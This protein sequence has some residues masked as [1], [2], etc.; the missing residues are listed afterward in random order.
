[1][2][3][4]ATAPKGGEDEGYKAL[5]ARVEKAEATLNQQKETILA[6]TTSD[7]QPTQTKEGPAYYVA[8]NRSNSLESRA[9]MHSGG[10]LIKMLQK[11]CSRLR[12]FDPALTET[13]KDLKETVMNAR[14]IAQLFY[15]ASMDRIGATEEKDFTARIPNILETRYAKEVLVPKLKAFSTTTF[16]DWVP[17]ITAD[18]FIK[19][20]ELDREVVAQLRAVTMPSSPYE[21]PTATGLTVARGIAEGTT[22]TDSTFTDGKITFTAKKFVE[23]YILTEEINEDSAPD[24]LAFGRSELMAAHQRAYE[25]A[26]LN[27]DSDGTHQDSDTQAGAADLAEKQLDG[28]RKAALGNSANGGTVD[29]ANAVVTDAKLREMRQ[30]MKKLGIN[31]K[32]CLWIPGSVS[33]NQMLGTDNVVT[34]DKIGDRATVV[35]G[36]LG[37]YSGI[38]IV[39]SG[40]MREDLNDAGVHDGITTDRTGLLLIHKRRWYWGTRRPIRMALRPARSADDQMEIASYSR[41][42]FQGHPQAADEVGAVYGVDIP[43]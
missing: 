32:D 19:E 36:T 4:T 2:A 31:P 42:D 7:D 29:F 35:T 20:F 13:I 21:L 38:P 37:T 25:T 41:V 6:Q 40:F 15:G 26:S 27:G 43:A 11:D 18:F 14:I 34:I 16:A 5:L 23:Y 12:K 17:T 22:A 1:M 8:G 28:L 10:N 3:G 30:N 39:V 33:Y 9:L 24:I